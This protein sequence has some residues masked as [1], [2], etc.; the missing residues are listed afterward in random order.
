MLS[1]FMGYKTLQNLSE[2]ITDHAALDWLM[3]IND[4]TGRLARWSIYIQAYN[5]EIIHR[6]GKIHSNVDAL[7]RPVLMIEN[8]SELIMNDS[9]ET[10]L[11]VYD[12]EYLICNLQYGRH[13]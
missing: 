3:T 13:K 4:P 1:S 12:D 7:S 9:D 2:V 11:D 10:N 5:F 8:T 6:K